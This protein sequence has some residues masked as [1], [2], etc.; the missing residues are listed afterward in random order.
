MF[1]VWYYINSSFLSL[2]VVFESFNFDCHTILRIAGGK[3]RGGVNEEG[4]TYYNNLIN[5]LLAN[6]N[7]KIN[8][9]IFQTIN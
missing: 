9:T 4:I 6:G 3:I 1:N 8:F 2:I 5:E 7:V